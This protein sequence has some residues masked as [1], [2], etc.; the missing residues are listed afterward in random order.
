MN[1]Y[2]RAMMGAPSIEPEDGRCAICNRASPLER[3]HIVARS[4]GGTDGPTA[5]LCGFGSNLRDADGR[6]Y[7]HG[8]AEWHMLSFRWR[9]GR[10]EYLLTDEPTKYE[11][12]LRMDGWRPVHREP[13]AHKEGY[14]RAR[15]HE[16]PPF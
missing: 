10:W 6:Y 15:P 13:S 8:L 3:H 12:A 7:C 2:L 14:W 9:D 5:L 16:D 1:E 4:L 11:R